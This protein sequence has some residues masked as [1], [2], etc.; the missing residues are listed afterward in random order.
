LVLA[1]DMPL[2]SAD[3]LRHY[4]DPSYTDDTPRK[5]PLSGGL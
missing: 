4:I 1:G 5:D 2:V 3:A